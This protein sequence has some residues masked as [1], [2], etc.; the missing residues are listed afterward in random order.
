MIAHLR[1]LVEARRISKTS[2]EE[3]SYRYIVRS[4]TFGVAEKSRVKR[5]PVIES[6][7]N[8]KAVR[9]LTLDQNI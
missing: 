6:M 4:S 8:V 1:D 9:A 2:P 5:V 7:R 3:K